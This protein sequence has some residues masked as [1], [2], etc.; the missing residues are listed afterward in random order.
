MASDLH[1]THHSMLTYC[2][3]GMTKEKKETSI[4][5]LNLIIHSKLIWFVLSQHKLI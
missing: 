4:L 1:T 3:F 5:G 2:C